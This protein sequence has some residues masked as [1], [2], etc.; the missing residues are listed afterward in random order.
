MTEMI[1]ATCPVCGTMYETTAFWRTRKRTCGANT[2]RQAVY[3][4]AC[5]GFFG[6]HHSAETRELIKAT[7][8]SPFATALCAC[9]CGETITLTPSRVTVNK[10][11]RYYVNPQHR[12]QHWTGERNP[13][14]RGGGTRSYG[15]GWTALCRR[16][17]RERGACERCGKTRAQNGQA[18][19]VHHKVPYRATYDNSDENL[20]VLCKTCHKKVERLDLFPIRTRI[21]HPSRCRQCGVLFP[22]ERAGNRLCSEA[23]AKERQALLSR[24]C[25]ERQVAKGKRGPRPGFQ[26]GERHYAF[27]KSEKSPAAKATWE[28]VRA[29]RQRAIE[30]SGSRNAICLSLAQEFPLS[31]SG[32]RKIVDGVTWREP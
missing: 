32:I 18:L 26:R 30:E 12:G 23:C 6:K 8:R 11:G 3:G 14:W 15:P 31:R 2:C 10:S 7:R 22:S 29:I 1:K 13:S 16:L 5:N 25:Y 27:G 9:G 24:A 21:L 20:E 17:R 19:D 4:G 28:M